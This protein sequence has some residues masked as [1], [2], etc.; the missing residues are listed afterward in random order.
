MLNKDQD[1]SYYRVVRFYPKEY[2]NFHKIHHG[3]EIVSFD[4]GLFPEIGQNAIGAVNDQ[5]LLEKPLSRQEQIIACHKNPTEERLPHSLNHNFTFCGY[6]LVEDFSGISAITNCDGG[7]KK[8]IPYDKLNRFGLIDDFD[9]AVI[10]QALL[11]NSR[12]RIMPIA[13]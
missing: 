8:V 10:T 9:S 6:D 3:N 13:M 12:M 1:F 4:V 11:K 2:K 5:T 7:F